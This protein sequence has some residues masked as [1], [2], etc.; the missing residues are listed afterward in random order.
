MYYITLSLLNVVSFSIEPSLLY[1][2]QVP[3]FLSLRKGKF[4]KEVSGNLPGML[5]TYCSL[6]FLFAWRMAPQVKEGEMLST[7]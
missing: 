6:S 1:L 7:K 5:V 4:G 2:F 3:C